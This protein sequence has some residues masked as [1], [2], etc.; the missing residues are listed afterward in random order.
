MTNKEIKLIL[1]VRD[2][3]VTQLFGETLYLYD[4]D[5]KKNVDIYKQLGMI[6][7]PG[8]DFRAKV[9]CNFNIVHDGII[10]FAGYGQ[11]GSLNL[12]VAS[13]LKGEGVRTA[14]SHCSK[15][16]VKV[17]DKVKAGKL[18]GQTGNSGKY[19]NA[20]HLH[21]EFAEIKNN[22]VINRDNGYKGAIDPSPYFPKNWDKSNA[23]HKYGRRRDWGAYQNEI[24]VMVS[25]IRYLKRLPTH[26]EIN[27][28]T[29]GGWDREAI[30]NPAMKYNWAYLKKNEF[31]KGKKPFI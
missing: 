25:L 31:E 19:T 13:I 12:I 23:W 30:K 1:P 28:C 14:Y 8:I 21:F 26:E 10:T 9:G 17:G 6:G 11:S 4:K 18:G 20:P 5:K 22:I 24:K 27:A 7:H 3:F 2:I 29:Y 15:L 16:V